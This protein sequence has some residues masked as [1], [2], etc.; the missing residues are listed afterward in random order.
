[1]LQELTGGLLPGVAQSIS[2][3]PC[4]GYWWGPMVLQGCKGMMIMMTMMMTMTMTMM[5]T[6]TMTTMMTMMIMS[7]HAFKIQIPKLISFD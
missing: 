1:M 3:E 4:T 7:A 5:M 2:K 6:M